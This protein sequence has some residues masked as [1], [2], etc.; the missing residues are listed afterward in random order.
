MSEQPTVAEAPVPGPDTS[1]WDEARQAKSARWHTAL[2]PITRTA[3]SAK[4][5]RIAAD[6][7]MNMGEW[8][9][10]PGGHRFWSS[11]YEYLR[12]LQAYAENQGAPY[13]EV[14]ENLAPMLEQGSVR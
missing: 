9:N 6:G 10:L 2:P 13:P 7:I 14:P 11:L 1:H 4:N 8:V 5:L 12:A 3:L